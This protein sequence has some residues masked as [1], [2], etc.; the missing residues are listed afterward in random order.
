M[1]V[2]T[3]EQRVRRYRSRWPRSAL[4][5]PFLFS[6]TAVVGEISFCLPGFGFNDPVVRWCACASRTD[7]YLRR[8]I[9]CGCFLGLI[10]FRLDDFLRGFGCVEP[11]EVKQLALDFC[12]FGRF[13]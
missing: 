11:R 1:S 13:W 5:F 12:V 7:F 6:S 4:K 9:A 8:G 2:G 3:R 10:A